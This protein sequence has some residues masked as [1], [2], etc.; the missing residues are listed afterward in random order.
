M[1]Y[2]D[3]V[4]YLGIYWIPQRLYSVCYCFC[5]ISTKLSYFNSH[6]L[7]HRFTKYFLRLFKRPMASNVDR[8]GCQ[9]THK[10]YVATQFHFQNIRKNA[11]SCSDSSLVHMGSLIAFLSSKKASVQ[12]V[13]SSEK[14]APWIG[15]WHQSLSDC[16]NCK[17]T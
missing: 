11:V 7:W 16:S 2:L 1:I 4:Y 10:I 12:L 9:S 5:T 6:N 3:C 15:G 8:L 14:T 17:K 13:N